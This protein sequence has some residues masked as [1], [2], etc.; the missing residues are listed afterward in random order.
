MN[1]SRWYQLSGYCK[2]NLYKTFKFFTFC[3]CTCWLLG[4]KLMTACVCVCVFVFVCVCVYVHP[5]WR[6]HLSGTAGTV[7]EQ[8]NN[9]VLKTSDFSAGS[10]H[11]YFG[12]QNLTFQLAALSCSYTRSEHSHDLISIRLACR[13]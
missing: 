11:R 4:Y 7:R 2:L 9:V 3:H 10:L 1:L 6:L 8:I 5:P 13:K 12:M